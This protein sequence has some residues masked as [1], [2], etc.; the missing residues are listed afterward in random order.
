[1]ARLRTATM[2]LAGLVVFT[3]PVLA[4]PPE[5]K[6]GP[7]TD[8]YGDPL[9]EGAIARLGSDRFRESYTSF[10]AVA[11]HADDKSLAAIDSAGRLSLWSMATG[12]VVRDYA[13]KVVQGI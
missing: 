1:M 5:E 9:P 10:Y 13:P 11:F 8:R 2:L 12:R 4:Q 3:P 6:P 7:R